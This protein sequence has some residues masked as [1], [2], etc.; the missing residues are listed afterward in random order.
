MSHAPNG[1]LA[2]QVIAMPEDTNPDGDIFGGWLLSQM[3]LAA[4]VIATKKAKCRVV[5]IA[6]NEMVFHTPVH[7]GDL[8]QCYSDIVKIGNTSITIK[9][10]AWV[11]DQITDEQ[12]QVT[13]GTFTFVAIDK[14]GKP[15]QVLRK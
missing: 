6:I 1:F 13:E 7:I 11:V 15:Q 9:V 12:K 10:E 8:V 3:D 2:I 5:T 4:G 14:E